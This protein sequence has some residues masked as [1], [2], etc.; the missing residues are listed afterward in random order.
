M[1]QC[2]YPSCG[3][4]IFGLGTYCNDD[5]ARYHKAELNQAIIRKLNGERIYNIGEIAEE[6]LAKWT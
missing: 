6:N 2:K 4:A 3:K 1:S 5:C